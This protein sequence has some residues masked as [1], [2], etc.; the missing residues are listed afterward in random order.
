M[1]QHAPIAENCPVGLV[2]RIRDYY[3][4]A[5]IQG[6]VGCSMWVGFDAT[7]RRP[8]H[9]LLLHGTDDECEAALA[10]PLSHNLFYGFDTMCA[11]A[12]ALIAQPSFRE[13]LSVEVGARILDLGGHLGLASES[14][15]AT[16]SAILARYPSLRFPYFHREPG[17]IA[18]IGPISYRAVQ[19]TYQAILL[20]RLGATSVLE[21]GGGLGRTALHAAQLGITDYTIVDLPLSGVAQAYFLGMALGPEAIALWG[22][23]GFD[24]RGG[25]RIAPR[26]WLALT[27]D[28]F[29][30]GLNVDSLPEMD[31]GIA[32]TYVD[33]M[34][35][36]CAKVLSIN[37]EELPLKASELFAN[38]GVVA[39]RSVYPLRAGYF[40]ELVETSIARRAA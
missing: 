20:Q 28:C 31:P 8:I 26:D 12:V 13:A 14:P 35:K 4:R 27:P 3:R 36:R 18:E 37:H 9:D 33:W 29:S 7:Q 24:S 19:A 23:P 22:E 6:P 16:F 32:A 11:D 15:A 40:E 34:V 17:F 30:V 10:D 5:Q 21:I 25:I 1:D 39:S 38:K 2:E